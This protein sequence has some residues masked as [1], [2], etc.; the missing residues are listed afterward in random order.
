MLQL[1]NEILVMQQIADVLQQSAEAE[2]RVT[3]LEGNCQTLK[4]R[5][6]ALDHALAAFSSQMEVM[7]CSI[8]VPAIVSPYAA[9][10]SVLL[11]RLQLQKLL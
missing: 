1:Y 8:F 2:K 4:E 10:L 9:Q 6:T 5:S 7:P 3:P 11:L